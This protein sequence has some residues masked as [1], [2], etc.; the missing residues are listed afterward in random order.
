MKKKKKSTK[1]TKVYIVSFATEPVVQ[2]I[3]CHGPL[4]LKK[5]A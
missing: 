2:H 4:N 1:E 5:S 3:R